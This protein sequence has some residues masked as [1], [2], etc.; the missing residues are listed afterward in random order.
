VKKGSIERS[1]SRIRSERYERGHGFIEIAVAI[2]LRLS[3]ATDFSLAIAL[4]AG[5]DVGGGSEEVRS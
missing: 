1:G 5:R 4:Q 2:Q 3:L